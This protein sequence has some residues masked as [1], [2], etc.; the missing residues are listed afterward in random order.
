M[1]GVR[2]RVADGYGNIG[3]PEALMRDEEAAAANRQRQGAP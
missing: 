1:H 2:A 3:L